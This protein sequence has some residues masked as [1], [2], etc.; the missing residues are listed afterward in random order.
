MLSHCRG[1]M[2]KS[3][4]NCR[5]TRLSGNHSCREACIYRH[6]RLDSVAKRVGNY[7]DVY[8]FAT[9]NRKVNHGCVLCAINMRLHQNKQNSFVK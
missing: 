2:I 1:I 6:S 4:M 5:L 3:P 8:C 7:C 9:A